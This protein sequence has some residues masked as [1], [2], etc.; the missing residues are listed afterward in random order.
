MNFFYYL[1]TQ[2]IFNKYH[3]DLDPNHRDNSVSFTHFA[4]YLRTKWHLSAIFHWRRLMRALRFLTMNLSWP[5]QQYIW[6]E[7]KQRK[8][9]CTHMSSNTVCRGN[10]KF[11]TH[12]QTVFPNNRNSPH[13]KQQASH[14]AS[15]LSD[16]KKQHYQKPKNS[17]TTKPE[18]T[19]PKQKQQEATKW[20][21][22]DSN[23]YQE[24]TLDMLSG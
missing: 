13:Y 10:N 1:G 8:G 22:N 15:T 20:K 5:S 24:D 14:R 4:D 17:N 6:K 16:N 3:S 9:H 23:D 7:R 19:K 11:A 2:A 12:L 18:F 21:H